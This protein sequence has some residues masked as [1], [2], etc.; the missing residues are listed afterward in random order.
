M[1]ITM[2]N[3]QLSIKKKFYVKFS[4]FYLAEKSPRKKVKV[5]RLPSWLEKVKF[6]VKMLIFMFLSPLKI[7]FGINDKFEI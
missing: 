1:L 5:I 7:R 2:K 3:S 4:R 6:N